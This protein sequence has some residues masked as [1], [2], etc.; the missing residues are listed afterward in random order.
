MTDA[1]PGAAPPPGAA[2]RGRDLRHD[3][4]RR[5]AARGHLA[6]G[7]RQ[8]A[9]RRAARLAR[10]RTTSRAAGP[11]PTRRT[12]SSSGGPPTELQL[13]DRDAGRVRLDPAA[14]RARS[15]TTPR[16]AHL[17][18]GRHLHGVHRRQE[19]GLPRHRGAAHHARRGRGHGRR[20]GRSSCEAAGLRVFFDA[21]HFFDGYKAQPRVRAAGAR[22]RGRSTAPTASCCATPTAARCRT[23][24]S[25]SPREVVAYFGGDVGDRHPPPRRHRLRGGQRARRRA[26]AAPP[27]CR[28]RS[29]A[30]ASA[31]ATATSR[32][33]SRT[34]R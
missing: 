19:L 9:H 4:A 12:T 33:S 16:C 23:R 27:R 7:R 24:W 13:D 17:R 10:R 32:R 21:E 34:S 31:P 11:G 2:R 1:R 6:H 30:T 25:A 3:A 14:R 5:R 26:W 22:G 15:T 28:A 8:A 18:R 20:L 29:T